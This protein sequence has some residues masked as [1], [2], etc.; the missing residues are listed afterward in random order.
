[1]RLSGDPLS[2]AITPHMPSICLTVAAMALAGLDGGRRAADAARCMGA[3][4]ALLPPQHVTSGLERRVQDLTETRIR[5]T[6]DGPAYE[7]AYAEGGDLS[8][9]E[10]TALV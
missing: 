2:E 10:A 1:M 4:Q 3:A 5:E 7:A 9:A 6:L 8:L